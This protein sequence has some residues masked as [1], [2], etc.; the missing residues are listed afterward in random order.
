LFHYFRDAFDLFYEEGAEHPKL[1]S[2]G[3][4]DR[5]VGRPARAV[6]LIK[7]LDYVSKFDR[8]WF[9]RGVDIANHWRKVH[10]H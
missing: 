7:F 1:L 9:C 3:L 5:L 8:V 6:G 10:P 4:H 2:I